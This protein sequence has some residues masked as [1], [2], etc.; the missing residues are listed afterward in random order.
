M[1]E[2]EAGLERRFGEGIIRKGCSDCRS[3]D[4]SFVQTKPSNQLT[5]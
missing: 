1:N 5:S 3:P 4:G 2:P